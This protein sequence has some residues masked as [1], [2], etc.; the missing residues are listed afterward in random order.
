MYRYVETGDSPFGLKP[1][2]WIVVLAFGPVVTAFLNNQWLYVG[3]SVFVPGVPFK[4]RLFLYAPQTR[5]IAET[6]SIITQ[7]VFEHSLRIRLNQGESGKD[8]SKSKEGASRKD[9][10]AESSSTTTAEASEDTAVE[11]DI[12]IDD[13]SDA[14]TVISVQEPEKKTDTKTETKHIVG[15]I[16]NLITSD[17]ET[18]DY[19]YTTLLLREPFSIILFSPILTETSR[20]ATSVGYIDLVLV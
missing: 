9:Q 2:V 17:L 11:T 18:L 6:D 16:N 5:T 3:V 1:W 14:E 4:P 19:S 13:N 8:E 10:T 12:E 15:R 7:L 20:P